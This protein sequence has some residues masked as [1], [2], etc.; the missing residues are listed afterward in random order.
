MALGEGA[1]GVSVQTRD[2]LML[3]ISLLTAASSVFLYVR[4]VQYRAWAACWSFGLTLLVFGVVAVVML[5]RVLRPPLSPRARDVLDLVLCLPFMACSFYY[6]VV[7]VHD[8][9]RALSR[10]AALAFLVFFAESVVFLV[11]ILR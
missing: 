4:S 7:G 6:Y 10:V 8:E 9:D 1:S 5:A 11:R 2:V 3:A